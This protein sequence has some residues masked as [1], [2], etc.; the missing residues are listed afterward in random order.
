MVALTRSMPLRQLQCAENVYRM[1]REEAERKRHTERKHYQGVSACSRAA[2]D[3]LL[4]NKHVDERDIANYKEKDLGTE[5]AAYLLAWMTDEYGVDGFLNANFTGPEKITTLARELQNYFRNGRTEENSDRLR[6]STEV[7]ESLPERGDSSAGDT[8]SGLSHNAGGPQV[9]ERGAAIKNLTST[10]QSRDSEGVS[11]A[12]E[13]AQPIQ[14]GEAGSGTEQTETPAEDKGRASVC[15]RDKR[16]VESSDS[17]VLFR[18]SD[19][20]ERDRVVAR[21]AYE[22]M[23]CN[24]AYRCNQRDGHHQREDV[25]GMTIY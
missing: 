13:A 4:E 14:R 23:V 11:G 1:L 25:M 12:D 2:L 21:D 18:D 17:D 6:Q 24:D 19:F 5:G 3:W 10:P 20:T 9:S 8:L 16:G 22:I 7:G 15:S